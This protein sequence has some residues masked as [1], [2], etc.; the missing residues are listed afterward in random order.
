M[1]SIEN[2]SKM[3]TAGRMTQGAPPRESLD[4]MFSPSSVAVIGATDRAGTVGL[5]VLQNLLNP[6][7][8]GR[9]YPVKP[10]TS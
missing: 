1:I 8:R 7:F 6:A 10:P 9:V 5:T 2:D 4:A 3:R